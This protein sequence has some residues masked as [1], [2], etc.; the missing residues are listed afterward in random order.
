MVCIRRDRYAWNVF[1]DGR[2]E[3][4]LCVTMMMEM[5]VVVF[6]FLRDLLLVGGGS[7]NRER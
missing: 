7:L 1:V 4:F 3:M 6:V 5:A 2:G